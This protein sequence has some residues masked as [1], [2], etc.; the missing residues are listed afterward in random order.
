MAEL[1]NCIDC[2]EVLLERTNEKVAIAKASRAMANMD[3]ISFKY[4]NLL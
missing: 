3:F 2:R 4:F 1:K